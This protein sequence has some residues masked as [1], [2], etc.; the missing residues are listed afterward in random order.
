MNKTRKLLKL[1][2]LI[3]F[4]ISV[5]GW[6]LAAGETFVYVSAAED[7]DIFSY[8]MNKAGVLTPLGKTK[9]GKL[10]M[11]MAVSR[12]KQ[13]LYAIVR[14]EPLSVLTYAIDPKTGALSQKATAPLPDSM[15]YVST[16]ATGRFLFT[17]S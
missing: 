15:A 9:A 2:V 12:N 13:F 14:S 17:A 11:P 3:G 16:D 8:Q 1:A 10:V 6:L 7:G 5:S 4:V